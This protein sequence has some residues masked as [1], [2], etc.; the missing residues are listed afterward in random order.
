MPS[1]EEEPV[2]TPSKELGQ[3]PGF[4]L[5]TSISQVRPSVGAHI[6]KGSPFPLELH[7]HLQDNQFLFGF[8]ADV[9]IVLANGRAILLGGS[10]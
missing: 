3:Y 1:N 8:G 5:E 4:G 6:T 10:Q 9:L 2:I 7:L